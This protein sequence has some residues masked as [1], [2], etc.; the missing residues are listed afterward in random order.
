[1][2]NEQAIEALR[3]GCQFTIIG[4]AEK[5]TDFMKGLSV[6]ISVLSPTHAGEL[7]IPDQLQRMNGQPV[8][9]EW[10]DGRI[11]PRWYIVGDSAW[12]MM[13][14]DTFKDYGDWLAYKYP[15]VRIDRSKWE[16]C[17][18]CECRTLNFFGIKDSEIILSH[19][20]YTTVNDRFQFC[21]KC[22][23][24]LTEEAWGELEKRLRVRESMTNGDSIRAMSD[25]E[26]TEYIQHVQ[27]EAARAIKEQANLTAK[28]AFAQTLPELVKWL[29][30]PACSEEDNILDFDTTR[31]RPD[32]VYRAEK[33]LQ[34]A[35]ND[36][37]Q[38][39]RRGAP[40]ANI[41]NLQRKVEYKQYVL[42]LMKGR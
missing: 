13:G 5:V 16:P 26:L 40:Q 32:F 18:L 37:E 39:A 25:K 36:L 11:P 30:Q 21:P 17:E 10:Q 9:V 8:L 3:L 1:M 12:N 14:F 24:P 23:R 15:P 19:S 31:P 28:L 33:E 34:K 6:A 2:T 41:F 4:D 35:A 27:L 20:F 22:G 42:G 7:L 38:A 29:G